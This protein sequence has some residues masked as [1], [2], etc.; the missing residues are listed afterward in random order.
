MRYGPQLSKYI[1]IDTES[2]TAD[3]YEQI[4]FYSILFYFI[5]VFNCVSVECRYIYINNVCTNADEYLYLWK[6]IVITYY[7]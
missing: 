1:E 6:C 5:I 7:Y 3:Y 4:L 2:A